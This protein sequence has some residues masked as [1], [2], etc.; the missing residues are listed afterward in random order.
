VLEGITG[1]FSSIIDASLP[2]VLACD[3]FNYGIEAVLVHCMS[4]GSKHP[5]TYAS[6]SLTKAERNYS[7]VSHSQTLFFRFTLGWRKK[8]VW[9]NGD[10]ISVQ[11]STLFAVVT[12]SVNNHYTRFNY[13]EGRALK[14]PL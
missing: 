8:S 12:I 11:L 4:D 9:Y 7:L 5:I 1:K 3:A 2:I 13:E 6:G 14:C 10:T